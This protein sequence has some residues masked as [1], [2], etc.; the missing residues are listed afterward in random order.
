ML[1]GT[2]S[3]QHIRSIEMHSRTD[4]YLSQMSPEQQRLA[5]GAFDPALGLNGAI[6]DPLALQQS[7]TPA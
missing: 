5:L 7:L 3:Q 6:Q 2:L 4:S 1:G